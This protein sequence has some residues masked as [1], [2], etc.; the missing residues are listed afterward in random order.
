ME[1]KAEVKTGG[2]ERGLLKAAGWIAVVIL[3]SKV[4]GFLRDVVV[5]NYYGASSVSDAY[6]YAYQIPALAVVILGGV[7]GPFHSATVAVFS[8][9]IDDLKAKPSYLVKRLF[10]NFETFSMIVFGAVSLICCFFSRQIMGI[11]ING[12]KPELL[13][14]AS[15]QLRLMSPI[16]FFGSV[17]GI[18]Y[19]ILVTHKKF[20][21]PNI[22][23]SFLS[24]G[25]ITTLLITKG[26]NTGF[27][28]AL[29]TTIGALS[30]LLVQTPVVWK[31]GYTP[32]PCFDFFKDKNFKEIIE[33]LFPA[34]LSSSIGQ[35]GI[36]IDMFFSASLNPGDWT[37]LGYANRIF[38]FPTGMIL[39]AVL[40]PLFPLFSRLVGQKDFENVRYYFSKGVTNLF[41]IA[42]YVMIAIFIVRYDAIHIAL[43]R[44][45]FDA[46]ATVVVADILFFVSLSILPYV[47]RDSCTR[48]FY[49]FNDS[50]VP[51]LVATCSIILKMILNT[52][53]V[54][55]FGIY[56]ISISTACITLFNAVLLGILIRKKI[57]IGYRNIF[58]TLG[59]ILI[60][61]LLAYIFGKMTS[62]FL[63]RTLP[64]NLFFGLVKIALV[65]I[66][67]LG[68]Y[69]YVSYVL[70]I[71]C[72]KDLIE[73]IK[74]RYARN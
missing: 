23:P 17:I 38:Q 4:V 50:K 72:L 19:G 54:K 14:L 45:A 56:G 73:K 21:L 13:E 60:A 25:I 63:G 11:I 41:Y 37:S 2:K 64:W 48:L 44:G 43:Q 71:E 47:F 69:V 42:S 20:V 58:K 67:S 15:N 68:V 33:L 7:G 59:K 6:F 66:V 24:I 3:V 26:D 1:S 62:I 5:A 36:Y 27:Y 35:L 49:A 46:H 61:S 39:T 9:L 32:R 65:G 34:F 22:S 8:K 74:E 18:Y 28:L 55:R 12:A 70:K 10:N 51:F 30:Q 52:F 57:R 31:L 29:G 16:V 53:L 40:V